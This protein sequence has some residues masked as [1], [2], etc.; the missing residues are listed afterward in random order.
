MAR[1]GGTAKITEGANDVA[2]FYGDAGGW[3]SSYTKI[4]EITLRKSNGT[5]ITATTSSTEGSSVTINRPGTFLIIYN[6][7]SSVDTRN[8]GISLNTTAP[9]TDYNSISASEQLAYAE[10][11]LGSGVVSYGSALWIGRLDAGDV[12]RP[13]TNGTDFQNG[14]SQPIS[15]FVVRVGL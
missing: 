14:S 9:S 5:G 11:R 10:G 2:S 3:G 8:H 6:D 12:V 7:Q 13:H 15:F 1:G 4:R